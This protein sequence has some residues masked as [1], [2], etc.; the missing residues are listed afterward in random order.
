LKK[1]F[2]NL[3]YLN[4]FNFR[5]GHQ[6]LK[7]TGIK[8]KSSKKMISLLLTLFMLVA[9]LTACSSS[10]SGDTKD[11]NTTDTGN[12]SAKTVAV[13]FW[14]APNQGQYDYWAAK[15]DEFNATKTEVDGSV[16]EVVVQQMPES[17]SSEAGIQNS[18]VTGTVPA[19]S[20]NINIGFAATLA[21]SGVVYEL[22]DE[23]WFK[24]IITERAIEEP[25][26]GWALDGKQYVIPMYINPMMW[27]WNTKALKALGINEVPATMADLEAVIAAFVENKDTT[28]K[29]MGV[30]HIL[31]RP[32]LLRGDQWWDRWHDFQMPY[33]A[34]TN[35]GL[36]VEGNSLAL[37]RESAMEAFEFIGMFGNGILTSEL[38]N[39]WTD[40]NPA[41]LLTVNA[42]WEIA[43]LREANKVYGVDYEYGPSIV[44]KAGDTPYC[45]ADSK[46]LV[47]YK[48]KSISEE[49]HAGAVA[50]LEWL[51]SAKNSSKTDL[52]WL[53]ATTMLP[54]RGDLLENDVFADKLAEY[55]EL[56]AL[57]ENIPYAL[58]S[59]SHAKMIDIQTALTE[60]GLAP[61]VQ[62]AMEAEPLN[63]PDAS[64]YVDDAFA[65]MKEAGGLE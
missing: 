52:D 26:K 57:A 32:S 33:Q 12:K 37:N 65:A 61:Y 64:T 48:D 16:Y 45:F 50:F 23:A 11:D 27:Q 36:W 38:T 39:L 56:A 62:A 59:M 21:E 43:A 17:P 6:N 51:F 20:E 54:V 55:P 35:G 2:F 34:F 8:M 46:G 31:Y 24:A 28:M 9:S 13:D 14:S 10:N 49:E 40:E 53:N 60:K 18:I 41:V 58:P 22:Q 4:L 47:L 19:I 7:G 15:A 3:T 63:A 1:A 25:I 29:D 42:P 30:S 5:I 44:K